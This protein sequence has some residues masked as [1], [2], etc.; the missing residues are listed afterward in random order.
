MRDLDKHISLLALLFST[1]NLTYLDSDGS[2]K[3]MRLVKPQLHYDHPVFAYQTFNI[4]RLRS[5]LL[6]GQGDV[7]GGKKF[8]Q[9]PQLAFLGYYET[10]ET[11]IFILYNEESC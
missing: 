2:S 10:S 6:V 9:I 3:D 1:Y 11:N 7:E 5:S 8:S 4:V